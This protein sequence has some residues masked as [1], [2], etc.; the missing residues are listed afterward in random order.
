[1]RSLPFR[2]W[3][4]SVLSTIAVFE[5]LATFA[6]R[7]DS[8]RLADPRIT[9]IAIPAGAFALI[10]FAALLLARIGRVAL[11]D[12]LPMIAR[13]LPIAWLIPI[14]D[15]VRSYGNGVSV[16][17]PPFGG[18]GILL[19]SLTG[20][21]LPL[22]NGIAL[23]ARF[24]VFTGALI[25]GIAVWHY[26]KSII[27]A[28]LAALAWSTLAIHLVLALPA[29]LFW[30]SPFSA[31]SWSAAPFEVS[32]RIIALLSRGY[33][34]SGLYDRFIA[35]VGGAPAEIEGGFVIAAIALA[36][37][38]V[39]LFLGLATQLAR[40]RRIFS[41]V[42]FSWGALDV[43]LYIGVGVAMAVSSHAMPSVRPGVPATVLFILMIA[44]LRFGAAMK[45]NLFRL[46][47][48]ERDGVFQPIANGEISPDDAHAFADASTAFVFSS[49]F[50]LGW[51]VFVPVAAYL[52]ASRLTR[53]RL[54]GSVAWAES[55]Y[56]A[57]GAGALACA[58]FAFASQASAFGPSVL[59]AV[60]IAAGH[61]LFVEFVW[62]PRMSRESRVGSREAGQR[63]VEG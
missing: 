63:I 60:G 35:S 14:I 2:A 36:V 6:W 31:A 42:F 46:G 30:K 59:A 53:E 48:D 5:F 22:E 18:K 44:I 4:L 10:A 25:I 13:L 58:G 12:S 56:R 8:A 19:A 29:V 55:A 3:A 9:V 39:L 47:A 20:G 7:T 45:R 52:A 1:M 11:A 28:A 49:A 61:R 17:A 21:L 62:M 16:S 41:H 24:G 57:A 50:V 37:L 15:L 40:A 23:G 38:G 54:A 51:P 27:P 43:L 26:R 32:R 33:W 34:S